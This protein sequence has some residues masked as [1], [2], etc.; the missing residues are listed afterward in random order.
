[1]VIRYGRT[2]AG[3]GDSLSGC[4]GSEMKGAHTGLAYALTAWKLA[5]LCCM[6]EGRDYWSLAKRR[7]N[8]WH[9]K[10]GAKDHGQSRLF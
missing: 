3:R 7:P 2:L 4:A 8:K 5:F 1:M 9:L 6:V 10:K